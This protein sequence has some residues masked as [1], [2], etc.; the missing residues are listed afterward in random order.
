MASLWNAVLFRTSHPSGK[1]DKAPRHC[2]G[3]SAP[4]PQAVPNL[5]FTKE[6]SWLW[7]Y[8][9]NINIMHTHDKKF[10]LWKATSFSP[11]SNA[12]TSVSTSVFCVPRFQPF[13][14][15][16]LSKAHATVLH[17]YSWRI[18]GKS[19]SEQRGEWKV[20]GMDGREHVRKGGE[21]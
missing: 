3:N 2:S 14:R 4:V 20:M 18:F 5:C 19:V 15:A 1:G 11:N 13:F 7:I 8:I 21:E 6:C 16:F 10:K 9:L 12:L 17:K